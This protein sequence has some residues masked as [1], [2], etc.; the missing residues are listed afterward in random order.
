MFALIFALSCATTAFAASLTC[1]YCDD[2]ITSEKAYNEHISKKCPVLFADNKGDTVYYCDYSEYGCTA[3]FSSKSEYENHLDVCHFK[4]TTWG[5]KV[6]AF[7]A[8]LDYAD[9]TAVL[10]KITDALTG[11]GLPGLVVKVIDLLE[12]GVIALIGEIK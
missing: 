11:I 4:K 1:P 3:Y 9:F 6:E 10:D 2:I 12:Q 7:F 5:D 8:D